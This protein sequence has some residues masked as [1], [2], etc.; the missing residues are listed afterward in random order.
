MQVVI[1]MTGYGS[2]FKAAGYERLKPFIEIHGKPMVDWVLK[3]FPDVEDEILFICRQ[4]H[5]NELDYM[6]SELKKV[7]SDAR[8]YAIEKWEKKGP[9]NDVLKASNLID[10]EEPV[11]VCYCDYYMQWDYKQFKKD[12]ERLNCEGA[13]PCY[14]GFHPHLLPER[15]VYASCKVD[16]DENLVEIK[17]KFSWE[18]DK[19]K[20]R[21]SAGLYYFKTGAL[22]KKYFQKTVDED[23]NLNGEY[24]ASLPYNNLVKD[25]LKVWC[26]NNI[27]KFCQWGTPEDMQEYL[28]WV[29]TIKEFRV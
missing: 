9:V 26:P 4:E 14:S 7:A 5:L 17:E 25:G 1:P 11:L 24:Y 27:D 10:N 21:H 3:M 19:T 8:I 20:S 2:R 12:V 28:F 6:E 13:I 18:K 23:D 16:G 29:E 22:M 15:N